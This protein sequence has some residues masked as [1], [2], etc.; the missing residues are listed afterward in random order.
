MSDKIETVKIVREG[1]D[2]EYVVINKRDVIDSD[3]LYEENSS[4][5]PEVSKPT[6]NKGPSLKK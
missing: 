4:S 1:V 5:D 3:V 6:K 2:S